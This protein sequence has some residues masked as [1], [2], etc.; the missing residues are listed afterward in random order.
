MSS[1]L[2]NVT[3]QATSRSCKIRTID[4]DDTVQGWREREALLFGEGGASDDSKVA[5]C[6]LLAIMST[7]ALRAGRGGP[8]SRASQG[9]LVLEPNVCM[10]M[11]LSC[12]HH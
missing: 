6:P 7:I 1:H 3:D 5:A 2:S 9:G 4:T 8:R 11:N 12:T 10:D